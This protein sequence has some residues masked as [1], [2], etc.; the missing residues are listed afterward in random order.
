VA[1]PRKPHN[2]RMYALQATK[3]KDLVEKCLC[4]RITFTHF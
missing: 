3:K 4:T 1:T 2:D